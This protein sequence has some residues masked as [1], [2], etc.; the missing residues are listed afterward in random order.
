MGALGVLC[1]ALSHYLR[2]KDRAAALWLG[3]AMGLGV[4]AR[5][6]FV[7][8]LVSLFGAALLLLRRRILAPFAH[9]AA[10]A[11]GGVLGGAP[12]LIY[13]TISRGGTWEA[14][15]MFASQETLRSMLSSRLAMFSETLLSDWEHRAIWD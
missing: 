15:G 7:W 10:L 14:V 9:W 11:L 6:N 3:V 2:Q 4:W 1:L 8:L 12:F 5:A 13:Q